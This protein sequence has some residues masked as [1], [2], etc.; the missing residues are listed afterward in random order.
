MCIKIR[1][2]SCRE[3]VRDTGTIFREYVDSSATKFLTKVFNKKYGVVKR[4][5]WLVIFLGAATACFFNCKDR[6]K[7]LLSS[8]TSTTFSSE[9]VTPAPFPA[10]TVCNLNR[11]TKSGLRDKGLL[12]AA[13]SISDIGN[14]EPNFLTDC[15][16]NI[17]ENIPTN[18]QQVTIQ[19]LLQTAAQSVDEFIEDCKFLG[20]NCQKE[21][22]QRTNYSYGM[23]YTF[24]SYSWSPPLETSGTGSHHGLH[25]RVNIRQDE[26]IGSNLVDAGVKIFIHPLSEPAQVLDQGIAVP[27]GRALYVGMQRQDTINKAGVDCTAKRDSS[28]FN[29]L[30]NI[31]NYSVQACLQDCL[32]TEIAKTCHCYYIKSE[33]PPSNPTYANIPDC[34]FAD[35]CCIEKVSASSL[36]CNCPTSCD[37][38]S[39]DLTTSYSLFPAQYGNQDYTVSADPNNSLEASVYFQ[40]L[41]ISKETT[42]FSYTLTG[43]LSDMGGLLGLYLGIGIISFVEF[44]VWVLEEFVNW[45][46]CFQFSVQKKEERDGDDGDE[47]LLGMGERDEFWPEST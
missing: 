4:L 26:Y 40:T 44:V 42:T 19:N 38:T 41:V 37:S 28:H 8:P 2:K 15:E 33:I 36:D 24:N 5:F 25:F 12:E 22:F 3:K 23:C 32:L 9:R 29:F 18:A 1:K 6:V 39:F 47:K 46:C 7:L 11:I 31:F 30:G 16:N 45:L 17:E 27:P 13:I 43:L 14:Q 35:V 21:D 34:T 10:V 20:K